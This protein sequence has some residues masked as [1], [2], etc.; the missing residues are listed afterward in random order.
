MKTSTLFKL[1]LTVIIAGATI[2]NAQAQRVVINDANNTALTVVSQDVRHLEMRNTISEFDYKTINTEEGLFT[3]FY[4]NVNSFAG[5][6]GEPR[7]PVI[8]KLIEVPL[9]AELKI[10][11]ISYSEEILNLGEMGVV[12]PAFP[13]PLFPALTL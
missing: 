1:M 12:Y 4:T 10:S 5:K 6:V 9:G 8:R 2:F 7:I 11:D 13:V 3:S